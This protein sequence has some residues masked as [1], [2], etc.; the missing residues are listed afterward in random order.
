MR[1][2]KRRDVETLANNLQQ[3]PLSPFSEV[4]IW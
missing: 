2:E 1:T 3:H 4:V